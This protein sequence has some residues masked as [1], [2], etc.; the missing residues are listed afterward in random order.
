MI[1][2]SAGAIFSG[3]VDLY[4]GRLYFFK[5]PFKNEDMEGNNLIQGTIL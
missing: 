5:H 4:S 3:T 2:L 1:R